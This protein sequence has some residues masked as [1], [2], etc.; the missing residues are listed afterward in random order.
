MGF[1]EAHGFLFAHKI[2][3]LED[4]FFY[5]FTSYISHISYCGQVSIGKY[6]AIF[7]LSDIDLFEHASRIS[8]KSI[9]ISRYMPVYV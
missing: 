1:V 5:F 7:E 3:D 9:C 6:K 4:F 2:G 8:F